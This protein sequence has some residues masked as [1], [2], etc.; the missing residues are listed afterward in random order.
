MRYDK[1]EIGDLVTLRQGFAI[2]KKTKHHISEEPTALHLLRISDM[3][4]GTF[5]IYVKDTIPDKF[6]AKE[7]D[8]IYTRTGQ[9]GLVF[10]NQHGVVHNNCFT[11][12]TN[13]DDVLLQEFLYYVLQEK[14]FY[15]EANSRATGA[16]QPD[17]PHG[18]FNSIKIFLPPVEK[19][20]HITDI[21]NTYDQLIKNNQK[22]I[23]LLEEAAQRLYKEWF[24]DLRFPGYEDCKIVDRVPEG[25]HK[26][27]VTD[28]LEVK[29]GKDHKA[30][31]DGN[32]PVYGSG[33][34]MRYVKPI[35]Y[36]GESVLIPRKGSLNN[37]LLVSGD[38]WTIDTMFFSIP[39]L[40]NI[41]KYT[42][43][44]LK[45]L[46]M[47]SF[48]IGAAVPSMTVKILEGIDILHPTDTVLEQFERIT[49]PIFEMKTILERQIKEAEQA[50]DRLLPKLMTGELEV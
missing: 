20:K 50:R 8:I 16:A 4:D 11:V 5:S 29:Y 45:G 43:L 2:N 27:K 38:F 12:T 35:L 47:Y 6:I 14:A 32:I 22:Q 44:F 31:A 18:A 36:S 17:L 39:K 1:R 19:Q 26:A 9:V 40:E 25:W 10:R 7:N 30:L 24:I 23:I 21:L 48:N 49:L 41:A 15:E 34:V 28:F 42:Y 33:G 46:D 13:D 37:I 3:K